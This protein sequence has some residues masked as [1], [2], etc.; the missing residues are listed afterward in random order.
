MN[1]PA[2]ACTGGGRGTLWPSGPVA[3][4]AYD[5]VEPVTDLVVWRWPGRRPPWRPTAVEYSNVALRRARQITHGSRKNLEAIHIK[6]L[7][8]NSSVC[9]GD[10]CSHTLRRQLY[11]TRIWRGSEVAPE[12]QY[13]SLDPILARWIWT[14]VQATRAQLLDLDTLQGVDRMV[15]QCLLASHVNL[16][17]HW[18]RMRWMLEWCANWVDDSVRQLGQDEQC[19]AG[20]SAT[21]IRWAF[22]ADW[23]AGSWGA[24]EPPGVGH[25]PSTAAR[26]LAALGDVRRLREPRTDSLEQAREQSTIL[27]STAEWR[28]RQPWST[29]PAAAARRTWSRPQ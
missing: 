2:A 21:D 28:S 7:V 10:R 22:R 15:E 11:A 16:A 12:R 6:A 23:V 1:T 4:V 14:P 3:A 20:S 19:A 29:G 8:R 25:T 5:S 13:W 18:D 9:Q 24:C 27:E 17:A 26:P